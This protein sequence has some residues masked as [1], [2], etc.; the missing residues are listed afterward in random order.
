MALETLTDQMDRLDCL[1]SYGDFTLAYATRTDPDLSFFCDA[2]GY[3]AYR[4]HWKYTYVLGDPVAP[5]YSWPKLID[6]FLKVHPRSVFCQISAD[7]ACCLQS[8]GYWINEMGVDTYLDLNQ[9]S[10]AGK[11]RAGLRYASNWLTSHGYKI[12]ER[13]ICNKLREQMSEL[14]RVWQKT[15]VNKREVVFLNR[16][17][18]LEDEEDVRKVVLWNPQG[19]LEA[20]VF[21]DPLYRDGQVIGYVTA[22]KRRQPQA[23]G[24]AELGICKWAI[25]QFQS[26]GMEVLRLGLSPLA[27]IEDKHYKCILPLHYSWRYLH[28]ASWVNRFIY[29]FKGHAAFKRR[30]GGIEEKVHY[31]SPVFMNDLRIIGW[32]KLMQLI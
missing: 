11:H 10:L 15:R 20:F 28:Q 5:K 16:R 27:N 14:I 23:T 7:A 30:F 13:Q 19:G 21:F 6:R 25:E 1:K 9:Y 24:Y 29:N 18:I 26:E 2:E 31:A 4:K 3:I 22:I 12:E 8:I 17:A 32:L